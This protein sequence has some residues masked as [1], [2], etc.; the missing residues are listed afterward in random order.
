MVAALGRF[1]A[2]YRNMDVNILKQVFPA[3]PRE[4]EQNFV[5]QK[6]ACKAT[7]IDF[8]RM[9]FSFRADG[10]RVNVEVPTT[11]TCRPPTNQKPITYSQTDL[12]ILTKQGSNWFITSTSKID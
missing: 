1:Q 6:S 8:G 11:Y 4:T 12:F 3:V 5:R 2:A 9:E 7:E 10:G